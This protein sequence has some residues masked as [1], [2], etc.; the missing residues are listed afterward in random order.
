MLVKGIS[1][2]FSIIGI[3]VFHKTVVFLCKE[4]SEN[5]H[6]IHEKALQSIHTCLWK[7]PRQ[8]LNEVLNE[9]LKSMLVK[10]FRTWLLIGWQHNHQ[11]IKS[12]V[13]KS[14]LINLEFLSNRVPCCHL[15]STF[16]LHRSR[17]S[18]FPYGRHGG[19]STLLWQ[20]PGSS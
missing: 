5:Q 10:H 20:A 8:L 9:M 7:N 19:Y 3:C 18:C 13:R 12:H 6:D 11:P 15:D 1:S 16:H 4:D 2:S 17:L 14:L